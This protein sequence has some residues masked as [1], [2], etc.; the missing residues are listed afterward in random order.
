M[1]QQL[2]DGD[3]GLSALCSELR[4]QHTCAK[5]TYKIREGM[6]MADRN[7]ECKR[8]RFSVAVYMLL[9]RIFLFFF[10]LFLLLKNV[11]NS[12]PKKKKRKR[13]DFHRQFCRKF[14]TVSPAELIAYRMSIFF[15]FS[16]DYKLGFLQASC[17]ICGSAAGEALLKPTVS[18]EV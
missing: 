4:R 12:F 2:L 1:E 10:F 5:F 8:C 17:P 7:K 18:Y 13:K 16:G 9:Y 3:V 11:K 6:E 15:S 14:L